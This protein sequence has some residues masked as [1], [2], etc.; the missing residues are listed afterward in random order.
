MKRSKETAFCCGG[1]G[2]RMW[3]DLQGDVKMSEVRIRE[4]E[5]TGAEIVITACPLC[6]IMLEDA[7]KA[8]APDRARTAVDLA[9]ACDINV[10]GNYIFGLP[11]DT[12]ESMQATLDLALELKCEFANFYCAMAYPGSAL[13]DRAVREGMTLPESWAGYSQHSVD[14]LPLGTRYLSGPEV[15]RFRDDAFHT[16]FGDAGYLAMIERKFGSETR[17]HVERMSAAR[18]RRRYLTE[19]PGACRKRDVTETEQETP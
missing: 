16:Y 14:T 9:R 1:G 17:R 8:Y 2:G 5:A 4:A 15:L 13:Y 10:I 6:L 18:L 7:R 3:Q 12:F 19:N 11:E